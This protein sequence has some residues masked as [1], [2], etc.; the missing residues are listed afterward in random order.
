VRFYEGAKWVWV[1][2][3]V[4]PLSEA[5]TSVC[6]HGL[7][8]GTGVFEGIRSYST[9]SGAGVFRLDAHL[10]RLAES[11]AA[12][13]FDMPSTPEQLTEGVEQ[14]MRANDCRGDSYIRIVCWLGARDFGLTSQH[15][16][17]EIAIVAWPVG[18]MFPEELVRA[19]IKVRI[20]PWR[21]ID[22]S[23]IPS[24][25]KACGQY[26]SSFL[27][28]QDAVKHGCHEALLLNAEGNLAEGSAENIFLIQGGK[29]V[30]NDETS[31]ILLG[32]TRD[33][34]IT[35]ARDL[36]IPV[37]IRTLTLQDLF[38]AEDA[39]FTGTAAEIV[40][41]REIDGRRI[42]SGE[43]HV[44]SARIRE[45]FHRATTGSDPAYSSWIH[46][47]A[48]NEVSKTDLPSPAFLSASS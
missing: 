36:G 16:P 2:G 12:Y 20:S 28:A 13:G 19:G 41:I 47:F 29:L 48:L 6:A 43:A 34:V 32:I 7:H 33:S 15:L 22:R 8:Y 17:V 30:T 44:F 45:G 35:I 46:R 37:E 11:A 9:P 40:K 1:N 39:F 10:H 42:G 14:A 25:A 24:T 18:T 5:T 26:V 21:K 23:M 31:A 27:A 38:A 4:L 3:E